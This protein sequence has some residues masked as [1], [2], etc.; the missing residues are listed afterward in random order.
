MKMTTSYCAVV[1]TAF[2][3][4]CAI[5]QPQRMSAPVGTNQTQYDRDQARCK[6]ESK[7]ATMGRGSVLEE[8]FNQRELMADCLRARGYT[9]G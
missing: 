9:G 8:V 4:G 3:A 2:L 6:Y 1:V 5:P 7:A